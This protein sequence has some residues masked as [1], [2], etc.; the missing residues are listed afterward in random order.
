MIITSA[1]FLVLEFLQIIDA[2]FFSNSVLPI[3]TPSPK[4]AFDLSIGLF[5]LRYGSPIFER[6][7]LEYP[8][9]SSSIV[10]SVISLSLLRFIKTQSFENLLAFPIKFLRP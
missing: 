9:P 2:K 8:L 4:P 6:T 3:K 5:D 10:I 1:P 7:S